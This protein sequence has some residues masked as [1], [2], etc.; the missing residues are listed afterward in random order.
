MTD[1]I[2][3]GSGNSRSIRSIPS[4]ATLAPTYEKL[5]E[6]LIS[7]EGLPIDLGPLNPAGLDVRGS[8]L[9][10]A[11]LLK[12]STCSSLGIGSFSVPDD[13]F[14][15]L[16][17][18]VSSAQSTANSALSSANSKPNI[19]TGNYTGTGLTGVSNPNQL[20]FSFPPKMVIVISQKA[21]PLIAISRWDNTGY[22][23]CSVASY[24]NVNWFGNSI[25]WYV[26]GNSS[27]SVDFQCNRSGQTY[28][29]FA[30]G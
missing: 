22:I 17:S 1:T 24:C 12:D 13:A 19:A 29:Y 21:T 25:S 4:L 23:W 10:K 9:N 30:I 14:N 20:D 7:D 28:Y 26:T 6:M 2:I 27:S 8:D 15:R 16:R 18:L 3:K 5:L 11:N